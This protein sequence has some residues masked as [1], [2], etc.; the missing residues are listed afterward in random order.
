MAE[1]EPGPDNNYQVGPTLTFSRELWNAVMASVAARLKARELLEATFQALITQ[2]TQA[3]LDLIS[4]NVAPQLE[5]LV[6]QIHALED[7]LDDIIGGGTAPNALQLGGQNPSFYRALENATGTLPVEKVTGVSAMIDA[8]VT[9]LINGSPAALDTLKEL[10]DALGGDANFATSMAAALGNRLRFDA[11]QSLTTE[12]KARAFSN[13][14]FDPAS[15]LDKSGGKLTGNLAIENGWATIVLDKTAGTGA[16]LLGRTVEKARWN[17]SLGDNTPETGA[18]AGSNFA[19]S[20]H[21]DA[22][23]WIDNPISIDRKTGQMALT[24]RPIWGG[25]TPWDNYNFDPSS[26]AAAVHTHATSQIAGLD[27]ALSDRLSKSNGGLQVIEGTLRLN[28]FSLQLFRAGVRCHVIETAGDGS[29][30]VYNGD[31]PY[32]T[33]FQLNPS[34]N[35]WLPNMGWLDQKFGTKAEAYATINDLRFTSRA[36]YECPGGPYA[37]RYAIGAVSMIGLAVDNGLV[38]G[39]WFQRLQAYRNNTWFEVGAL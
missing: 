8:A 2:G 24:A 14:G 18:N 34:G 25:A 7:Q 17:I 12:Q 32:N 29:L 16:Q 23:D 38:R 4:Q 13:L 26:K 35:I 39:F 37:D 19:I 6:E 31:A 28:G 33:I 9:G 21:A 22:G 15:K 5:S 27:A 3:A 11:A 36:W 20:R 10:S 1:I 30:V